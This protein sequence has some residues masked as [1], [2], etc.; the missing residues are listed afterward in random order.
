MRQIS[1][2]VGVLE[3]LPNFDA[4]LFSPSKVCLG[5]LHS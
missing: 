5:L 1:Q 3:R 2:N 4:F